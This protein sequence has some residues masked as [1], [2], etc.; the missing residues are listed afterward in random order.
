M[1]H[2]NPQ[3]SEVQLRANRVGPH[4]DEVFAMP[5]ER[6]IGGINPHKHEHIFHDI[7]GLP[8]DRMV[9]INRVEDTPAQD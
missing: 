6:P 5:M 2:E 8:I 3:P 1:T 9:D 7:A 4:P